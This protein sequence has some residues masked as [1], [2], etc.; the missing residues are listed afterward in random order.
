M[1]TIEIVGSEGNPH[2]IF[3]VTLGVSSMLLGAIG[4]FLPIVPG[5]LLLLAGAAILSRE[6]PLIHRALNKCCARFP[7]V[8]RC[9]EAMPKLYARWTRERF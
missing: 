1:S 2:R 9:L 8:R 7:A 5:L 6:C 4:M 3:I